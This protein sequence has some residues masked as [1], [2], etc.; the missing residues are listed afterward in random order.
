MNSLTDPADW[1]EC[2]ARDQPERAFIKT[3]AGRELSYAAL[4][5]LSGRYAAALT[6]RRLHGVEVDKDGKAKVLAPGGPVAVGELPGKDLDL[7]YLSIRLTLVEKYSAQ[8]QIPVIFEDTFRGVV[9]DTKLPLVIRM[10]KHLGTLTQILHVTPL[11]HN[12]AP[13]EAVLAL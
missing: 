7:V 6:D 8:A 5:D 11:S 3:P 9:D 12:A 13:T 1:I 10:F 4:S 2:G